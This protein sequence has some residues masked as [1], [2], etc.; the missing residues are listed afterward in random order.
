MY[1]A[2]RPLI[3]LLFAYG[4]VLF[5]TDSFAL[6]AWVVLAPCFVLAILVAMLLKSMGDVVRSVL[7]T[8]SSETQEALRTLKNKVVSR[9]KGE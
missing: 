6:A 7:D 1:C 3:F 2:M 5:V 4:L 9:F 8:I